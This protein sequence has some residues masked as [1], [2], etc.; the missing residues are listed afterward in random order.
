M[1]LSLMHADLVSDSYPSRP[2][3]TLSLRG[4]P[5][6]DLVPLGGAGAPMPDIQQRGQ[7]DPEPVPAAQPPTRGVQQQIDQGREGQE[8]NAQ[9]RQQE[10]AERGVDP[11]RPGRSTRSAPPDAERPRQTMRTDSPSHPPVLSLV[12]V[13]LWTSCGERASPAKMN[14]GHGERIHDRVAGRRQ[15]QPPGERLPLPRCWSTPDWR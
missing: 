9:Q 6:G 10:G 12:P 4:A 3:G 11:L 5:A 8:D 14:R 2:A 1:L 13:R 15:L 7:H